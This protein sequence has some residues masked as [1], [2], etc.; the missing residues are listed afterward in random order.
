MAKNYKAPDAPPIEPDTPAPTKLT[1]QEFAKLYKEF[2]EQHGYT[3]QAFPV[4]VIGPGGKFEYRSF[5]YRVVELE[6]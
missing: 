6:K 4:G 2:C 5:E 3:L 1:P